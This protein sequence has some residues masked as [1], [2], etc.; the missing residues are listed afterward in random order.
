MDAVA[1]L[2]R[3]DLRAG[4]IADDLSFVALADLASILSGTDSRVIGGQM[5]QLHVH[6]WRLGRELYRQTE[7]ADLGVPVTAVTDT[8]LISALK[9]LGYGKIEGNRFAR[10]VD[11]VPVRLKNTRTAERLAVVDLLVPGNTSRARHTRRFGDHL[12]TTEVPGLSEAF[13]RPPVV[14]ELDL[15]RL[16]GETRSARI[17][18]PDEPSALILKV[19]AWRLR[20]SSKD[21]VDVWRCLEIG[22]A[23]VVTQSD[24]FG[25]TGDIVRE[26]LRLGVRRRD[27]RLVTDVV[28]AR[29]L[30]IEAGDTL[31]TR[32]QAVVSRIL[33]SSPSST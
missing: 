20:S 28:E 2:T 25:K 7:D 11:D 14:L 24:L 16:N 8:A 13:Q 3:L 23:A 6:R 10:V 31:H 9:D 29:G 33:D 4:S 27:G 32:L 26:V 1:P 19:M 5:V 22:V 12:V 17:T 30:S 18:I 21:A 15:T